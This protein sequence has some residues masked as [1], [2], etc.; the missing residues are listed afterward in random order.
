[1]RLLIVDPQGNGLDF[2][3]RCQ[4]DGHDVRLM[5]RQTE[6]TKHI[7][8]GLA[9]VVDAYQPWMRWADLVFMT[10]NVRY[11][12]DLDTRWRPE[13]V[14]IVG[15]SVET[16]AWEIDRAKGMQVFKK[17]GI[18]VPSYKEFTDYD[19]AIAYVKRE[20]RRFVSKPCGEI[21]DKS[22]SYCSKSAVDLV[23]M[24]QRWKKLGKHKASFILQEFID[25]VEMAVGGWFGPH[26]FNT[27]WCENFEFKKL[28]N[29]DMGV[30]TGEQ[31]T[32]LRYVRQSSLARR[33]LEPLAPALSRAKYVGY[34]DVNCIID[35]DGTP[36]PLEFTTRPGWPT[37]NIQ[38]A[39][40][41]GDHAQWLLDLHD[42]KDTRNWKFNEI[43][44]GVVVSMPDYPYS[45][46]TR[47]EVVGIPV[48][49]LTEMEHVHP[50]EMMMGLGPQKI[51]DTFADVP[52]MVTAGD[53]VLVMTGVGSSV[54]ESSTQ[55]YRRLK[56][57]ML[58]NSP[59]YRTDIGRRLKKQLPVL[60]SMG[61]ATGLPYSTPP[62]SSNG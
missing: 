54:K 33:V 50:C 31:G 56:N 29:D 34:I 19:Q 1:M 43:A 49:R 40:H 5:I 16:A 42:G 36:W 51:K 9:N 59:M 32:V 3:L 46:A 15:A 60:Q 17:A 45:H 30:A 28:M 4:K 57:L 44:T 37:F 53:Y 12:Y 10:D 13:G 52:M 26:G 18:P 27:G 25:G 48:Y 21:E 7:G 35:H 55:V 2:A 62:P 6:K 39:L 20:D 11:T 61:Y 41:Q 22:L 23:Y 24:L 38:Q 8:R 58:P 47:K 14:K